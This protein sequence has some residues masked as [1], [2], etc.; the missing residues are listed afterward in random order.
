MCFNNLKLFNFGEN[1]KCFNPSIIRQA[2]FPCLFRFYFSSMNNIQCLVPGPLAAKNITSH[3]T[4]WGKVVHD[5][6]T[7]F[8]SARALAPLKVI[9]RQHTALEKNAIKLELIFCNGHMIYQIYERILYRVLLTVLGVLV[10]A[11]EN[12]QF[13]LWKRHDGNS[14][15][16]IP[17][18]LIR[19]WRVCLHRFIR[20]ISVVMHGNLSRW[21]FSWTS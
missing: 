11:E 7:S 12:F 13:V 18:G 17:C 4:P 14:V 1:R 3:M 5:N 8:H 16:S 2:F 10:F 19:V 6:W 9:T 21:N 20:H 15:E